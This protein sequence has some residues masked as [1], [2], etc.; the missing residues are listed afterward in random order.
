MAAC[1]SV[2][3]CVSIRNILHHHSRNNI[4]GEAA[5][6]VC[7]SALQ[8]VVVHCSVIHSRIWFQQ[9]WKLCIV[10]ATAGNAE[11]MHS[12]YCNTLQHT[13]THCNTLQH[14]ATHCNTLCGNAERMHSLYCNTL[15]HTA[16]HCNTLCGNAERMHSLY[17]NTL[18]HTATHC[19]IL[20]GNAERMH[21]LYTHIPTH[22]Y[23]Y[24]LSLVPAVRGRENAGLFRWQYTCS[25]TYRN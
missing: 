21:S 5:R 14:T 20:C 23:T 8:C 10:S 24:I 19:N 22:T 12:L 7:R 18:Q 9:C 3:Q 6:T 15:Q 11:R 17:C 2:L 16:T 1:Y 4:L 25:L 13:A